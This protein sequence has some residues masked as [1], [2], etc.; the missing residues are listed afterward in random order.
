MGIKRKNFALISYYK[1]LSHPQPLWS[2]TLCGEGVKDFPIT[3]M[4]LNMFGS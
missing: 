3:L 4:T 1:L 2:I